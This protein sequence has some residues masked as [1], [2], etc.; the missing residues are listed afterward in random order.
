MNGSTNKIKNTHKQENM[1][2]NKI[3][4]YT[5]VNVRLE[6]QHTKFIGRSKFIIE[7]MASLHPQFTAWAV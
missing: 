7:F 1:T 2:M 3:Q 6:L 5:A 4:T